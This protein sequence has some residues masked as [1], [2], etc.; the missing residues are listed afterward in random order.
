MNLIENCG[1]KS[2][3]STFY[4][5]ILKERFW[6]EKFVNR[7]EGTKAAQAKAQK[8]ENSG[9][10]PRTGSGRYFLERPTRFIG[11]KTLI[12]TIPWIVFL[13]LVI[14]DRKNRVQDHIPYDETTTIVEAT[15]S[16]FNK[17]NVPNCRP[18]EFKNA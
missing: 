16:P 14:R 1:T 11:Q 13:T 17:F 7:D 10:C 2:H 18:F 8:I 12:A 9:F 5:N 15:I 4:G 3:R 6:A